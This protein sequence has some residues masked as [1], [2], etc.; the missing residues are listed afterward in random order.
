MP[1]WV[2]NELTIDFSNDAQKE[3]YF[4]IVG[5]PG[6]NLDFNKIIPMPK[7]LEIEDG[8]RMYDGLKCVELYADPNC[9][10][11]DQHIP[12]MTQDEYDAIVRYHSATPT[13]LGF[14][15]QVS[16]KDENV[17]VQEMYAIRKRIAE[18]EKDPTKVDEHW[19]KT[20]ELGWQAAC[21]IIN[22]G[23]PSWY[24]WRIT[25]W[26]TKWNV[27]SDEGEIN[28]DGSIYFSTA[29]SAP[30]PI[31]E[32]LAYMLAD[33]PGLTGT[34][35]INHRWADEDMGN[36]CGEQVIRVDCGAYGVEQEGYIDDGGMGR[37]EAYKLACDIWGWDPEDEDDEDDEDSNN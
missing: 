22:Y 35:L 18:Y 11:R 6:C 28:P 32:K 30:M 25:N 3:A 20:L 5:D 2:R 26:G 17:R 34:L 16:A 10:L 37:D 19:T 13:A 31:I 4:K 24:N 8:S 14:G 27:A 36:N 9:P 29:W 23:S 7:E 33:T 12:K 1:N 21:N 15:K